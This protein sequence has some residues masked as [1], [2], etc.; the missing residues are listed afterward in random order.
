VGGREREG[1]DRDIEVMGRRRKGE[2]GLMAAQGTWNTWGNQR[3]A[4]WK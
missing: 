4:C 3:L 1:E 2:G